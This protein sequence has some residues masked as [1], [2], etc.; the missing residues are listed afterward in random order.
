MHAW[1][2]KQEGCISTLQTFNVMCLSHC[3]KSYQTISS[4]LVDLAV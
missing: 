2:T 3:I 1:A 4:H